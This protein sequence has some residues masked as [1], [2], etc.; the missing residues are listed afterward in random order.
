MLD[1]C[2]SFK[3]EC[4]LAIQ[5]NLSLDECNFVGICLLALSCSVDTSKSTIFINLWG[6]C[7]FLQRFHLPVD[8]IFCCCC[9]YEG[10]STCRLAFLVYCGDNFLGLD[11]T[12]SNN[13]ALQCFP[14]APTNW[15]A[16][17]GREIIALQSLSAYVFMQNIFCMLPPPPVNVV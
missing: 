17:K 3:N 13:V 14:P 5:S 2:A 12:F 11:A 15:K 6:C 7:F 8:L 1:I 10:L 4:Q 16:E 9:C